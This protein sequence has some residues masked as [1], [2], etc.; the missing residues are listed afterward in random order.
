MFTLYLEWL[1]RQLRDLAQ[2][3]ADALALEVLTAVQGAYVVTNAVHQPY[4]LEQGTAR[5][6]RWVEAL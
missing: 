4:P 2:P 1:E 6:E 3:N 5:L